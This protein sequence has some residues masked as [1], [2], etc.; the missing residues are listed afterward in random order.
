[1]A[2]ST[3][4]ASTEAF[5]QHLQALGRSPYT[6][7]AQLSVLRCFGRFCKKQ[8]AR[9]LTSPKLS[10]VACSWLA[11]L[12]N[13]YS[14]YTIRDYFLT[15]RTFYRWAV[16]EG[17]A[18]CN[19]LDGLAVPRV[20]D[21][22]IRPYSR[23]DLRRLLRFSAD[24]ISTT[25]ILLLLIATGMRANELVNLEVN[26][27]D[28]ETGVLLIREGKGGKSRRV[29]PG[30]SALG[31]LHSYLVAEHIRRGRLFPIRP[32]SLYHFIHR[33]GE[34]AG[35]EGANCHRFRNTFAHEFLAA[36]GDVGDL[37]E[38]LGHSTITMSLR[39]A[40][41]FAGERALAAQR[42]Y[43]PVDRIMGKIP[44]PVPYENG[45]APRHPQ[46]A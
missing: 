6:V 44:C 20:R 4:A 13:L 22:P 34:R 18:G 30:P 32:D 29:A 15:L 24:N 19:P 25:A 40:S 12:Y 14:R 21:V 46:R 35:V 2:R 17:R 38:I 39:Y 23:S 43:N 5:R 27:V 33:L 28:W 45:Y 8:R 42:L 16:A 36:G 9:P 10:Q 41:Y 11:S 1:M 31:V 26:D 37:K 3:W 7:R